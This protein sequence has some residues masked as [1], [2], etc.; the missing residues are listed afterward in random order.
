MNLK[1][2]EDHIAKVVPQRIFSVAFHP[3]ETKPIVFAG[4]KWGRLGVWDVVSPNR[5]S[6]FV[7]FF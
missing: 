2:R 4:D 5:I 1:I 6:S 3:S 7:L